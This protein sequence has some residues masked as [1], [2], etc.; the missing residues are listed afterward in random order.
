MI[1]VNTNATRRNNV[2][3]GINKLEDKRIKAID[4]KNWKKIETIERVRL[5]ATRVWVGGQ[6]VERD[7]Q[8]KLD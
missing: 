8:G 4:N 3:N 6:C 5:A 1:K 7:V 2:M